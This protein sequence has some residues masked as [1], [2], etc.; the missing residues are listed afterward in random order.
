MQLTQFT[1]YSLRA[2]IYIASKKDITTINEIVEAYGIKKNHM[3]KIIHHLAKLNIIKTSR[4]KK[5]GIEIAS[6][7]AT[8]NLK[9]LL[10]MLEPHF[11]IVPCFS[12]LKQN[13]CIAPSCRLKHVL[14]EARQAFMHV[15][16]RY[17]L[18][19]MIS[20]PVELRML[21]NIQD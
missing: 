1:D 12:Q 14:Y 20:N 13:C 21:L 16:E 11:D 10:D 5:G 15:L 18:A 19:D 6:N 17:S 2:L 3:T 8:L 7:P 4:G 9:T